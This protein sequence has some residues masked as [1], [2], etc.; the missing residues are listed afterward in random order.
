LNYTYNLKCLTNEVTDVA[1]WWSTCLECMR[2]CIQSLAKTN[3]QK[4]KKEIAVYHWEETK[5][6]TV[7]L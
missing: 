3:K 7:A 6:Q 5:E 4:T 1:Q 2:P